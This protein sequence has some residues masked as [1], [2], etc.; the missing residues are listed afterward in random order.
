MFSLCKALLLVLGVL[1]SVE[2]KCLS[3]PGTWAAAVQAAHRIQA[4]A[5][6]ALQ[7]N[8]FP[9]TVLVDDCAADPLAVWP[10]RKE[11]DYLDEIL[12]RGQH[13]WVRADSGITTL[14]EALARPSTDVFVVGQ[15]PVDF[16][17]KKWGQPL[18]GVGSGDEWV[19]NV[20]F[21]ANP[22]AVYFPGRIL[23]R[24][25]VLLPHLLTG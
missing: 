19:A 1:S 18:A 6:G 17:Q 22:P 3:D 20:L 16:A 2:A 24:P 12:K 5:L 25:Q 15:G 21:G 23:L 7:L 13:V 8:S 14:A 9:K 10:V 4:D 11:G